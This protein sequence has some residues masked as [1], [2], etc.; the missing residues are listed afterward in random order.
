VPKNA[1]LIP[2][3]LRLIRPDVLTTNPQVPGELIDLLIFRIIN[4]TLRFFISSSVWG[5]TLPGASFTL[6]EMAMI[7]YSMSGNPT[8]PL[9]EKCSARAR[10]F[11][12]KVSGISGLASFPS[13]PFYLGLYPSGIVDAVVEFIYPST[14]IRIRNV[15]L[16]QVQ[17]YLGEFVF[18][19]TDGNVTF[20]LRRDAELSVFM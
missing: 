6:Q 10:W 12:G 4:R 2:I 11:C 18:S 5:L 13:D 15:P 7:Y 19:S 3:V 14:Y 9:L 1:A 8:M 16:T 17:S 20:E